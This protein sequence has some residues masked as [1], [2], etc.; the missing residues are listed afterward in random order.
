MVD[1]GVKLK[2]CLR[3]H[4]IDFPLQNFTEV[5]RSGCENIKKL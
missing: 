3:Y 4:M 5:I 1:D 2:Y